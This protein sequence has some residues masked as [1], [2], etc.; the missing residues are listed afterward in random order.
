MKITIEKLTLR[1]FKGARNVEIL[2]NEL[3]T[4]ING[5]NGT[6]KTTIFDAFNFLLWGKNSA[7]ES[8][9]EIKTL[10]S[11]NV[12]IPQL[13][14]EVYGV[15]I[16]DG[17]K[18]ELKR[19][20][21]EKWQTKRGS[22][23]PEMTGHDTKYFINNVPQSKGEYEAEIN[24]IFNPSI[25]RL[26]TDP[27]YFNL[28]LK[29]EQRRTILQNMAGEISDV[30]IVMNSNYDR[31]KA[32]ISDNPTINDIEK[33]FSDKKRELQAR[34]ATIKAELIQLPSRMDEV[35]RSKPEALNFVELKAIETKLLEEINQIDIE[36]NNIA[37]NQLKKFK[38][39]E[40]F[41]NLKFKK[42]QEIQN[43]ENELILKTNAERNKLIQKKRESN[44]IIQTL[45]NKIKGFENDLFGNNTEIE[46]SKLSVSSLRDQW[47]K[48]NESPVLDVENL[49]T[50]CPTCSQSLPNE[51]IETKRQELVEKA[52]AERIEKMNML[53][54]SAKKT[55]GHIQGLQALNTKIETLLVETKEEL[56][57]A[58]KSAEIQIPE[59]VTEV[60]SPELTMM[61]MEYNSMEE[62]TIENVDNS[63]LKQKK[64]EI[65]SD[66][67]AIKLKLQVENQILLADK[68]L[69]ELTDQQKNLSSEIAKID[70]FESEIESFT[71]EKMQ[72]VENR[73]NE[74]FKAVKFKMFETQINGG[75]NQTCVCT[76]NGVPFSDLNTASKINAGL[77]VLYAIQKHHALFAPV[78]ID[79][80]ES[81]TEIL[82]PKQ[83]QIINLI[84]TEGIEKLQVNYN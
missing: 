38:E 17:Q 74:L 68:R 63:D 33:L 52:N 13:E 31:L 6:G 65:Q 23:I 55:N 62:K 28:F 45:E 53:A 73:V 56:T 50:N 25:S 40:E 46:K 9:F 5:D 59:E 34:K 58:R 4:N 8:I 60:S 1:N 24:K 12:H 67:N 20:Y 81:I 2:F 66:L 14:H 84:K 21:S 61:K 15:L 69:N 76:L 30:Q 54:E 83:C 44:L 48:L 29:W 26:I 71:I 51:E 10:N 27:L 80:R 64:E 57:E 79:N 78:F 82:N 39:I 72:I 75:I 7:N 49:K 22:S 3:E 16:V 19:I 32:I 42:K 18:I 70:E 36:L 41:N 37:E 35:Q 43:L 77:D 11:Q 47:T